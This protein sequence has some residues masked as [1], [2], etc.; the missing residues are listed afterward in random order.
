M[1]K[2]GIQRRD[3]FPVPGA[4]AP[5]GAYSSNGTGNGW[6]MAF[7]RLLVVF[8]LPLFAAAAVAGNAGAM[9]I[10]TL[11]GH[12]NACRAFRVVV[13]VLRSATT[14]LRAHGVVLVRVRFT[15]ALPHRIVPG[16]APADT[17]TPST[18]ILLTLI[19]ITLVMSFG[20]WVKRQIP[21]TDAS[22]GL[23]TS[24]CHH[25]HGSHAPAYRWR[26]AAGRVASL[27]GY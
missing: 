13:L 5:P 15:C 10:M 19:I 21:H 4:V 2:S 8:C 7:Q 1:A 20:I 26:H 18:H 27:R 3:G 11:F 12:F 22:A 9:V 25:S 24:G 14:P 17:C 16:S 6:L 23:G